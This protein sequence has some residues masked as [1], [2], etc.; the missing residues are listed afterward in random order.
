[1]GKSGPG[2]LGDGSWSGGADPQEQRGPRARR[3]RQPV[4]VRAGFLQLPVTVEL[5]RFRPPAAGVVTYAGAAPGIV[6]GVIQ[7]NFRIPP[8]LELQGD[9]TGPCHVVL[10]PGGRS[11]LTPCPYLTFFTPDPIV[12]VGT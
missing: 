2:G 6:A 3:G 4:Q 1:M 10:T 9:C 12:W 11:S 5:S 8:F 7:I